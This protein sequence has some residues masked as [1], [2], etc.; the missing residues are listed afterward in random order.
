MDRLEY[1]IGKFTAGLFFSALYLGISFLST[2]L[3][4][5]WNFAGEYSG[6]IGWMIGSSISCAV[7]LCCMEEEINLVNIFV[8]L[9][10]ILYGCFVVMV[11]DILFS[12][13]LLICIL[14]NI[15]VCLFIFYCVLNPESIKS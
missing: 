11:L 7:L 12:N 3:C 10:F 15:I 13:A 8:S 14:T 9:M 6:G 4:V 5:N 2:Y 1:I